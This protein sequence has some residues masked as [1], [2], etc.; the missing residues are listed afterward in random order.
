MSDYHRQ[1]AEYHRARKVAEREQWIA[2]A[3]NAFARWAKRK[4]GRVGTIEVFRA[5]LGEK[6][7]EPPEARWWGAVTR[8]LARQGVIER[9]PEYWLARSSHLSPKPVWRVR[10]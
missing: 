2:Q 6:V 7:E 4:P 9:T 5:E 1:F 8:Y 3:C 10:G